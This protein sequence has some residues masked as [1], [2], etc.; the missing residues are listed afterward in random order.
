MHVRG[1]GRS[2]TLMAGTDLRGKEEEKAG[3]GGGGEG[4][5]GEAGFWH[6]Y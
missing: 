5:G 2:C 4:V 3:N 1:A 6:T